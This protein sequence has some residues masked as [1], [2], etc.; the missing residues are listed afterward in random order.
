M[1]ARF[2]NE[3]WNDHYN[4]PKEYYT[5]VM[6]AL[7]DE[8]YDAAEEYIINNGQWM[9]SQM[10]NGYSPENTAEEIMKA[11]SPGLPF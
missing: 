9:N 5:Q 10:A 7:D 3:R 4:D 6:M 8:D 1:K 11:I 2:V